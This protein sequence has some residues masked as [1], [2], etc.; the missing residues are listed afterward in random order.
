V[1]CLVLDTVDG[2]GGANGSLDA[3]QFAWLEREL[4]AG[5]RRHLQPDGS[6]TGSAGTDRLF[7]L[8]SH[9]TVATMDNWLA[10]PG[11]RRVLGHTVRDLLLRF[12]NVVLWVNGHTHV[13]GVTA[14]ARHPDA[15]VSGG[16][17]EVT[18]ASLIDWPQQSRL[19]E[20]VDNADG[21]LSVFCTIVDTAAPVSYQWPTGDPLTLAAVSRE[22]GG[23]D[24]Q[25]R[26]RP[27]PGVDGR[28]G[29]VTDRNVELVLPAPFPLS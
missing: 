26:A 14:H 2:Y 27:V 12:P 10:P 28:R 22:I 21:T 15:P 19:V 17:F 13:N 9:H 5:H 8:F 18:T 11:A 29:A 6:L 23:N 7:V 4:L 1:R 3:T 16:F 20:V 25:A 24:W